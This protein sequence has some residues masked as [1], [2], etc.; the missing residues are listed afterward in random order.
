MRV[1][2]REHLKIIIIVTAVLVCAGLAFATPSIIAK[3][4]PVLSEELKV[5]SVELEAKVFDYTGEAIKPEIKTV[6]FEDLNAQKITKNADEFIIEK[7]IDNVEA[8]QA[9]VELSLHGYQ[10]TIT[11]QNVFTI[12]PAQ[13]SGLQIVSATREAIDLTWDETI[14]AESYSLFKSVDGGANYVL[15][16]EVAEPSY[17]DTAIELN[18]VYDYY[19]CANMSSKNQ[20]MFGK[21]SDTVKQYTPLENPAITAVSNASYNTLRVEWPVVAGAVGYQVYRSETQ[22]GEYSLLTEIADGAVTSYTDATCECGKIYYYYIKAGQ[23]IDSTTTYG[24]ASAIA[25]GKTTPNRTSISGSSTDGNTKVSLSW[26]KVSGA[27]GYE[28]YKNG[29]L[30]KT[31][32]NADT[33]SWSE[34]GLSK[35]AEATY[36]VRAYC[37]V[38][39]EKVYGSYSGTYEKDVTIT[40]N[41]SGVS[42][43]VSVLTQYVG[44]SYV[45]GGTTPSGWDCSGFTRY[46]FAKHFGVS[47]GRTAADQ[48]SQGTAVSKN[49]RSA[50]KPG[51]LL[52]YKENGR[53]SHVAI[54]LG[55]G[56][57][58][59]ALNSKYDTLIQGVDYYESWDSKTSLYCVRRYF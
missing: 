15:I 57:M 54:Y 23:S 50:W 41:Y 44:Y 31:I 22:D 40:Y 58:I 8:G 10:G 38:N 11:A 5:V 17:T 45:Y 27:Q 26:K 39:N 43:D 46:V 7:Y 29:K 14:G 34:S 16:A 37:V 19:V 2:I 20:M 42:S 55:N 1:Y 33:L 32:D 52:F 12:Q 35:E 47:L 21:A 30:V 18:A 6:V 49:D 36:K 48:A 25:S 24:N 13:A 51:D 4:Q 56:Q 3:M 53:I 28:V 59:H 9:S